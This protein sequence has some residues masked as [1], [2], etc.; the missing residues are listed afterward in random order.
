[1]HV[2]NKHFAKKKKKI[3]IN[4]LQQGCFWLEYKIIEINEK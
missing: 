1:M 2:I 3:S 4:L